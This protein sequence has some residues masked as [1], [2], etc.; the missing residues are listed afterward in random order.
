[1]LKTFQELPVAVAIKPSSCSWHIRLRDLALNSLPD[2][3]FLYL[4]RYLFLSYWSALSRND[5]FT[6]VSFFL[7]H[8][9]PKSFHKSQLI[10]R[11]FRGTF[12]EHSNKVVLCPDPVF[13]LL[14]YFF[15]NIYPV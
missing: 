15:L 8:S 6:L 3:I 1:M 14:C 7:D 9:S 4:S 12:P 11:L 5:R 13:L 2:F 10:R